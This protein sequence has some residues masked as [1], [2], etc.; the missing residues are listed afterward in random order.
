MTEWLVTGSVAWTEQRDAETIT[1]GPTD[2]SM[3]TTLPKAD[4]SAWAEAA[5]RERHPTATVV[6]VKDV[7]DYVKAAALGKPRKA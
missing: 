7:E 3:V 2:W 6:V 4:A 5:I 1:L